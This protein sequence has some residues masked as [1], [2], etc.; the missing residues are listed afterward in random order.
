MSLPYHPCPDM[1]DEAP[2]PGDTAEMLEA[3]VSIERSQRHAAI[4]ARLADMGMEIAE[5]LTAQV[6]QT[7]SADLAAAYA[8]VAQA[9][10]RTIALEDHLGKGLQVQRN[11]LFAKRETRRKEAGWAEGTEK[12]NAINLV[13]VDAISQ[14]FPE[15]D[16]ACEA[17]MGDI[18]MLLADADEFEGWFDWPVGEIIA[19]LCK[20]MNLDP[21]WAVQD[22]DGRWMVKRGP[23]PP[24]V[25]DYALVA[26]PP[27]DPA[28]SAREDAD[29]APA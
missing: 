22:D 14:K 25:S 1:T 24:E 26:W 5:A 11:A 13:M 23:C 7:P 10:R 17:L 27:P 18:E 15:N 6:K 16:E 29:P 28:A 8:K 9:V 21:E 12:Q 2:P 19:R 4:L 3:K 20:A